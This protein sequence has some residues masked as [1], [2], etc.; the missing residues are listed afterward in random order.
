M[1]A[2]ALLVELADE[3]QQLRDACQKPDDGCVGKAVSGGVT[4]R[5]ALKRDQMIGAGHV[6]AEGQCEPVD[7]VKRFEAVDKTVLLVLAPDFLDLFH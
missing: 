2:I 1:I 7:I 3:S 4:I 5:V 6:L